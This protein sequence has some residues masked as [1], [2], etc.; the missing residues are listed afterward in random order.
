MTVSSWVICRCCCFISL[1]LHL[2][3]L[4]Y[5]S[6]QVFIYVWKVVL[7]SNVLF[8]VGVC[9][10][11]I[12]FCFYWT[13]PQAYVLYSGYQIIESTCDIH[14]RLKSPPPYRTHHYRATV[15]RIILTGVAKRKGHK[16]VH[17]QNSLQNVILIS[18]MNVC[19][20]V[21]AT[22]LTFSSKKKSKTKGLWSIPEAPVSFKA[23]C[24]SA[25]LF[26]KTAVCLV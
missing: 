10:A 7:L 1:W 26:L 16:V 11:K 8:S 4:M 2:W 19:R 6:V 17:S 25:G 3:F 13:S 20:R 5:R 14:N 23:L 9:L 24:W 21:S 12:S 18:E 22:K 15:C